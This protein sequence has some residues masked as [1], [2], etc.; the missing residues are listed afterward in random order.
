MGTHRVTRKMPTVAEARCER[1]GIA[2]GPSQ[3]RD[4]AGWLR[5]KGQYK[6]GLKHG[7]WRRYSQLQLLDDFGAGPRAGVHCEQ[8]VP[9][10]ERVAG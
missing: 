2:N 4:Y 3:T 7:R 9:I 5:A 8:K 6:D 1:D 10:G